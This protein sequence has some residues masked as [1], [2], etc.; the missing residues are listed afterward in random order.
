MGRSEVSRDDLRREGLCSG[1]GAARVVDEPFAVGE[2]RE[3][4]DC[5]KSGLVIR[6]RRLVQDKGA[7]IAYLEVNVLGL[8]ATNGPLPIDNENG[9]PADAPLAD[10][11]DLI[12]D[13]LSVLVRGEVCDGL[14]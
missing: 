4:L 7:E 9:D 5:V 14:G 3:D 8:S 12:F 2:L 10:T 6:E 1:F 13:G 11:L